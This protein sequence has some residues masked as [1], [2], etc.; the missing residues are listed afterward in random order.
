MTGSPLPSVQ[1]L[2]RHDVVLQY[3]ERTGSDCA[4]QRPSR[5]RQVGEANPRQE[6]R[7]LATN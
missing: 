2:M 7:I 1:F 5:I 6:I 4:A 3:V